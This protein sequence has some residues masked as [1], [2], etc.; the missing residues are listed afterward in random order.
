MKNSFFY[1]RGNKF[2]IENITAYWYNDRDVLYRDLLGS[3][4][5][6]SYTNNLKEIK[7]YIKYVKL[8]LVKC[9]PNCEIFKKIYPEHIEWGNKLLVKGE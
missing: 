9:V 6:V 8:D 7:I 1:C 5:Q 4:T 2:S 3:K